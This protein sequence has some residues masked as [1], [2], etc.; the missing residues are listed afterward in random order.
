[1]APAPGLG[2]AA[3]AQPAAVRGLHP[4][5]A[6]W[7]HPPPHPGCRSAPSPKRTRRRRWSHTPSAPRHMPPPRPAVPARSAARGGAWVQ[8]KRAALARGLVPA[9]R[10]A[11]CHKLEGSASV[12]CSSPSAPPP[13]LAQG[14]RPCRRRPAAHSAPAQRRAARR[15]R[16]PQ[17]YG[18]LHT[19]R[20]LPPRLP[21]QQWAPARRRRRSLRGQ[22]SQSPPWG[23]G[24]VA[25]GDRGCPG[26]G[27]RGWV[28]RAAAGSCG[29]ARSRPSHATLRCAA[30][31]SPPPAVGLQLLPGHGDGVLGAA[32][33]A[34][35]A[36]AHQAKHHLR[37]VPLRGVAVAELACSAPSDCAV[38]FSCST[39]A[40][41]GARGQRAPPQSRGALSRQ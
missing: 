17:A 41:V 30:L 23:A 40:C 1:V 36:P 28:A 8:G 7:T 25:E 16:R 6:S 31:R 18:C 34:A 35:D 24:Q 27:W 10:G 12:R 32:V 26:G 14:S 39:V 19:T 38:S 22:A 4:P 9:W 11:L 13:P 3:G 5:P 29:G 20:R 37:A 21:G 15:H 33:H 2:G